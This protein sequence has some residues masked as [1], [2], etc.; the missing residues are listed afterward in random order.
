MTRKTIAFASHVALIDGKEYDGIGN[1]VKET[2]NHITDDYM[3][4]RHSMDGLLPS[5]LVCY[6]NG[7]EQEHINMRV[8]S[9]PSPLRYI[10][11]V[12]RTVRLFSKKISVDVYVGIDPLNAFA[13]VLLK[14]A[15][16]INKTIF[17]TADYSTKR[18]NNT[19]LNNIY[20]R[21]DRYCVNNSDE[22]WSVSTRICE[23]R[24]KMG[25]NDEKNIFVP[26]VPPE[27]LVTKNL[28]NHDPFEL[29]TTGVI[30]NQ[31]DFEG[32]IQAVADMSE[33]FPQLKLTIIGNGPKEDYLQKIA[34][35]MK[36]DSKIDFTGRLSLQETIKRQSKAGIG[37]ALYTGVWGFNEYGDSTKCREFFSL[38]LPV[39][40]TDTHS[41][42]EDIRKWDAG[43]IV[44]QNKTDYENAIRAILQDYKKYSKNSNKAHEQFADIH[45]KLFSKIIV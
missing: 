34:K 21:I 2:L 9:K 1:V 4:V 35:D 40:S 44:N 31:L 29:I 5:E 26:N 6:K 42:V 18:F 20:H 30:D 14:R 33:E 25:L 17:Y 16:K 39:I 38:G 15:G 28:I 22:V 11:E 41:T 37:L 8:V 32:I 27:N 36:I 23:V 7:G 43:L 19:L 24:R 13:G 3:Y 12:Y 45:R 10:T